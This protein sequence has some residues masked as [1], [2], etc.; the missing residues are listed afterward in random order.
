MIYNGSSL[1]GAGNANQGT[2]RVLSATSSTITAAPV[3]RVG[4]TAGVTGA[5]QGTGATAA[6]EAFSPVSIQNASGMDRQ[7]L[8]GVTGN[9]TSSNLTSSTAKLSLDSGKLWAAAPQVN[10]LVWVP[11][12]F[13]GIDDG[14]YKIT[15]VSNIG[16]GTI[17]I[18]RLSNGAISGPAGSAAVAT[19]IVAYKSDI[20]GLGKSMEVIGDS[21]SSTILKN[22]TSGSALAQLDSLVTSAAERKAQTLISKPAA[23]NPVS[24]TFVCGG[25]I[26]MAIG[27]AGTTASMTISDT[28]LATSCSVAADDLSLT[29]ADFKTMKDLVDYINTKPSYSASI[30]DSR[31]NAISPAKLDNQ[32]ANI[33]S[34]I[35]AKPARIKKDADDW[36]QKLSQSAMVE[37]PSYATAGLPDADLAAQ[38]LAGGSKGGTSS[39]QYVAAVDACE[40]LDTNFLVP[41]FDRDATADIADSLTES[42]SDYTID[43]INAYA[44]SHCIAMSEVKAR[45][46]RMCVVAKQAAYDDCKTAARDLSHPRV[47]MAFQKCKDTASDGSLKAM[48]CWYT[49]AKTAGMSAVAGYKGIVKKFVNISGILPV[50][51]FD[52]RR[53]G[54]LEDALTS[55]LL[56]IEPVVSGGFR[57]VS[58]Q[59]TYNI[60]NNFVYN[61]I[62]A[63]YLA[64][65]ITLT[66]IQNADRVIVGE[67]V[68]QMSA[69]IARG[70]IQTEM[71]NF[72]RLN[73]IARSD[74]APLGYKNLAIQLTGGV[75][76]IEVEC[77]LA[78]LIFFVPISLSLSEV[79]Q[80]A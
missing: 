12:L 65:L 16:T 67:S 9:I 57:Y 32:T 30:L 23:L 77:K 62:Q 47:A 40:L 2:Y 61:S 80:S 35:S 50:A 54:D 68:A 38:F 59:T 37:V 51:G 46:N 7:V 64:D 58:D 41:A 28:T 66:L 31:W 52:A 36:Y 27:Y 43:A 44:K 11:T 15:A 21:N 78:G 48:P 75:M 56:I 6:A 5:A 4:A 3:N 63:V 76:N 69:S 49:A 79:S 74:D 8:S 1:S 18:Q 17:N 45:K 19:Q 55:G 60:D 25:D 71:S 70:F 34:S 13:A 14:W 22:S 53:R 26:V 42:S 29:L 10:E 24:E 33:A 20:D 72:L 73:W 39:A